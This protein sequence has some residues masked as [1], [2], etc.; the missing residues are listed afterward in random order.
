MPLA[1]IASA[2][3]RTLRAFTPQPSWFQLFQ[4]MGGVG[5]RPS[6]SGTGK[7]S[8]T[9]GSPDGSFGVTASDEHAR[10]SG[11]LASTAEKKVLV[12]GIAAR[13]RSVLA[14][15]ELARERGYSQLH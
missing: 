14:K 15:H 9:G 5:A 7:S 10:T 1:T 3:S 11:A 8:S 4:P 6:A 13:A 12:T 2:A